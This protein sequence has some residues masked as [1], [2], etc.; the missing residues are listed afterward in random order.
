[1][2]RTN[3]LADNQL[4]ATVRKGNTLIVTFR[5][6]PVGF[7]IVDSETEF[8]RVV[9]Y[10]KDQPLQH[11]IVNLGEMS[12]VGTQLI[13]SLTRLAEVVK[14]KGGVFA[15]C[16]P[17]HD[18]RE[19]FKALNIDDQWPVFERES[20]AVGRIVREPLWQK[21]L[22]FGQRRVLVPILGF[23]AVG[24]LAWSLFGPVAP[25][26][27]LSRHAAK[28]EDYWED[29]N[30][31][32]KT[33]PSRTEWNSYRE[34]LTKELKSFAD[35]LGQPGPLVP[36]RYRLKNVVELQFL[37]LLRRTR[38]ITLS[39]SVISDR[40]REEIQYVV[41]ATRARSREIAESGTTGPPTE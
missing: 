39:E 41:Q 18:T 1:M 38:P 24:L 33:A 9:K 3:V 8:Q 40:A 2:T 26:T 13:G 21:F 28:L 14:E 30:D 35:E 5:G 20:T 6:L 36:E 12:Y 10:Y 15:V 29:Y 17:S 31:F 25:A 27:R 34:S 37:P 11:V 7:G 4:Y 19:M 16:E 32:A 23:A 22:V